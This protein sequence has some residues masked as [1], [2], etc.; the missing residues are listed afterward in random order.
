MGPDVENQESKIVDVEKQTNQQ[1][2]ERS[3]GPAVENQESK[4]VDV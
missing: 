2:Q 3:Y 1:R 4:I